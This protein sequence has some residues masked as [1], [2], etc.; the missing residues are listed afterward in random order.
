MPME[1]RNLTKPSAIVSEVSEEALLKMEVI[2]SLLELAIL[3]VRL[4]EAA[5]KLGKSVRTVRR[6]LDKWEHFG[7]LGLTQ[8]E[9]AEIKESIELTRP[10]FILKTYREGNKGSKRMT[11]SRF[12]ASTARASQLGLKS[13]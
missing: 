11:L 7:M 5:A 9:R 4:S 12:P 2:K 6:L 1:N 8:T 3:G 13:P 10:G